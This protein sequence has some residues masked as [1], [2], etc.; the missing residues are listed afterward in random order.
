MKPI[1]GFSSMG[2]LKLSSK[3]SHLS[4]LSELPKLCTD[5]NPDEEIKP[6]LEG[7]EVLDGRGDAMPML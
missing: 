6:T 2:Q 4:P 3:V 7:T 1:C 5:L